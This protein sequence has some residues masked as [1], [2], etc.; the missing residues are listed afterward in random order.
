M[1][2]PFNSVLDLV[3]NNQGAESAIVEFSWGYSQVCLDPTYYSN[4]KFDPV[5]NTTTSRK[6]I[7]HLTRK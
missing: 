6:D 2:I 4:E 5:F 1:R 7:F 3:A